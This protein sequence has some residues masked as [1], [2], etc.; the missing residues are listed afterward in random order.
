MRRVVPCRPFGQVVAWSMSKYGLN[1]DKSWMWMVGGGVAPK[2]RLK[3]ESII[4]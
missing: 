1:I 2:S 4:D 3:N